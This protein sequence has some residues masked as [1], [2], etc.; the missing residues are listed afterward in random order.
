MVT[1]SSV[2]KGPHTVRHGGGG[3]GG[4]LHGGLAWGAA[5]MLNT[6][7]GMDAQKGPEIS[8]VYGGIS[9]EEGCIGAVFMVKMQ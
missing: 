8:T 4:G 6:V 5:V 9:P 2:Q 3:G 7:G 1:F